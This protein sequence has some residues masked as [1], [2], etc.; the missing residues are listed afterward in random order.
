MGTSAALAAWPLAVALAIAAAV[1]AMRAEV[2]IE[3]EH[4][5]LH[6]LTD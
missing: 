4:S 1:G 5:T 3:A 2:L 6:I